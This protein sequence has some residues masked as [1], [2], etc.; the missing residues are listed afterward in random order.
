MVQLSQPRLT[1]RL[2]MRRFALDD[3]DDLALIYA[4]EEVNRY[5]YTEPRDRTETLETLLGRLAK[6]EG[7]TEDNILNVAVELRDTKRV[8]GDFVLRW[9]DN[10]HRQ[11]EMG[12]SLHPDYQRLGVASEVY[13]ELLLL[14]FTQY[15]LHRVVGRCDAR[16]AASVRSLEKVGLHQEAH[17]VENEFVKDE[18]TDEIVMAIRK[19]EWE[20]QRASRE[21]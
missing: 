5:L 16:N 13:E 14:A 21:V 10:E 2:T 18:W 6:P 20:R 15:G 9:V 8:I 3:L 17:L 7:A 12:G 19:D 1:T 11:G 4:N